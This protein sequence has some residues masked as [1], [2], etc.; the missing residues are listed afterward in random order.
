MVAEA[1]TGHKEQVEA[2]RRNLEEVEGLVAKV[3]AD[4]DHTGRGHHRAAVHSGMEYFDILQVGRVAY[5][6]ADAG[7]ETSHNPADNHLDIHPAY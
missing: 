1:D 2:D 7:D 3:Q 4:L 6:M 5:H